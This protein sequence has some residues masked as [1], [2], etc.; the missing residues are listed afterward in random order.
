M[1]WRIK[2]FPHFHINHFIYQIKGV[3]I[4]ESNKELR[5]FIKS[6]S[7]YINFSGDNVRVPSNESVQSMYSLT[8]VLDQDKS[9]LTKP[10]F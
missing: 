4:Q 3:W 10:V 5:D 9:K 8:K 2:K 1:L 7:H 6:K